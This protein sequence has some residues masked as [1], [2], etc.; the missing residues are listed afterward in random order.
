MRL[1]P[2]KP[3]MQQQEGEWEVYRVMSESEPGLF[4]VVAVTY[5]VV[6]KDN[7]EVLLPVDWVCSCKGFNYKSW[8]WHVE[9]LGMEV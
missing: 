8:C 6:L 7:G 1:D 5:A 4:H 3:L 9:S 2:P